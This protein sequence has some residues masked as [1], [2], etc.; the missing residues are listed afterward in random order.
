MSGEVCSKL[1]SVVFG[2][3]VQEA[4][5]QRRRPSSPYV[6]FGS[7]LWIESRRYARSEVIPKIFFSDETKL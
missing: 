2:T 1:F 7:F 5:T 4:L 6:E 3:L